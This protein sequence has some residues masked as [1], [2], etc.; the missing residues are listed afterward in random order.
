M[1]HPGDRLTRKLQLDMRLEEADLAAIRALPFV[2][3]EMPAQHAI[4][5]EGERPT[6]SCLIVEGFACRC[7]TTDSGKR[8]IMSI[9]IPGD[10]PDLQSLH[11]EVMDHDVLTLSRCVVA[12]VSHDSLRVLTRERPIVAAALWRETLIDAAVFR[13]WIVN[14]GRRPAEGRMAHFIAEIGKRLEGVGLASAEEY[15]LPMTQL[16][17]ADALG[18]SAVHVN[19]VLQGLRRDGVITLRKHAVSVLDVP[20]LMQL[21]DFDDLYLHQHRTAGGRNVPLLL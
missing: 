15:E 2:T 13:E 11:L 12:F 20:R 8:Q 6:H 21:A 1:I 7:K 17:M 14:I 19:R 5:R 16:E 9:H 18:L 4:V 3:K 10:I